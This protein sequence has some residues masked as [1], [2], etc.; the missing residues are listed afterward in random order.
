MRVFS[1]L[2]ATSYLLSNISVMRTIGTRTGQ[3][4]GNNKD[5]DSTTWWGW[6]GWAGPGPG[7]HNEDGN[8]DQGDMMRMTGQGRPGWQQGRP[9]WEQEQ[10]PGPACHDEDD[11]EDQ[12]RTMGTGAEKTRMTMG[13]TR[14][15]TSQQNTTQH[16]TTRTGMGTRTSMTHCETSRIWISA[17]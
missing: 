6:Q 17:I 16:N 9:G 3:H 12:D 1:R 11:R 10:G 2:S 15:R 8:G 4:D 14:T 7:Q 5:Q 13:K